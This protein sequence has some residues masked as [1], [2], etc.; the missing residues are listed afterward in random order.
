L[1]VV[2]DGNR[3]FLPVEEQQMIGSMLRTFPEDFEAHLRGECTRPHR[4]VLPKLLDIIDGHAV[5][6]ARQA[7]KRPDWTYES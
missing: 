2:A 1:S 3:C 5:I 6:D 4:A 7:R